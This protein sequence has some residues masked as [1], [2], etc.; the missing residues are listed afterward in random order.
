MSPMGFI[1]KVVRARVSLVH[2]SVLSK[3]C[4][5]FASGVNAGFTLT[6]VMER[7]EENDSWRFE[8]GPFVRANG[9]GLSV[10]IYC[11]PHGGPSP[12]STFSH[13]RPSVL[14]TIQL[15]SPPTCPKAHLHQR[16]DWH[17][18]DKTGARSIPLLPVLGLPSWSEHEWNFGSARSFL[19]IARS[20]TRQ[21]LPEPSHFV[22]IRYHFYPRCNKIISM[23]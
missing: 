12:W 4:N 19:G 21:N 15:R 11:F 7:G 22:L 23:W 1:E 9:K 13:G 2:V 5:F 10:W 6:R 8:D 18:S 17:V 14:R 3:P 20:F 16:K